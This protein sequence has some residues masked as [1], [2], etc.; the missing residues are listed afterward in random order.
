M[1][2]IIVKQ[3]NKQNPFP[4]SLNPIELNWKGVENA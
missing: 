4:A 3:T 2:E 1:L